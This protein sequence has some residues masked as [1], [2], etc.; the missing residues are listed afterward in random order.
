MTMDIARPAVNVGVVTRNAQAMLRFYG[1]TLELTKT[2]EASAAPTPEGAS[3]TTHIFALGE[4]LLKLWVIDPCPPATEPTGKMGRT[5]VQ[6]ITVTVRGLHDLMAR[7][8]RLGHPIA[9]P[10]H[11]AASGAPLTLGWIQDPD[12]NWIELLEPDETGA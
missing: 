12:G 2:G 1:E 10:A 5:G 3:R 8:T 9:E 7:L 11:R 6:Y 4:S